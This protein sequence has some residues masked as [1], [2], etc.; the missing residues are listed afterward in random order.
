MYAVVGWW[1]QIQDNYTLAL[2][3]WSYSALEKPACKISMKQQVNLRKKKQNKA[4]G[5]D[6]L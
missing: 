5:L 1:L 6:I 2:F 3:H 4:N